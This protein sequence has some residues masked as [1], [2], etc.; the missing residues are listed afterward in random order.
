MMLTL[1]VHYLPIYDSQQ[2]SSQADQDILIE[3]DEMS[4]FFNLVLYVVHTLPLSE[5]LYFDFIV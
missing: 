2:N 3:C 4:F 1:Q 5:L